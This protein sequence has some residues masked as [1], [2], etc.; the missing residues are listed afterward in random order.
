VKDTGSK[1]QSKS[2]AAAKAQYNHA[3]ALYELGQLKEAVDVLSALST[4]YPEHPPI[5][6]LLGKAVERTGNTVLARKIYEHAASWMTKHNPI[7]LNCLLSADI[8]I[9]DWDNVDIHLAEVRKFWAQGQVNEVELF[10]LMALPVSGQDLKQL[11]EASMATRF[12]PAKPWPA[13]ARC[14]RQRP[15]RL[16][17]GYFSADFHGHATAVLMAG[18][19]EAHDKS[20]FETVG[21]CFGRYGD[22]PDD[23]MRQR[24]RAAFD[25]FEIVN[26]MTAFDIATKARSLNIDIAVD[27]KGHT[28]D[29]RMAIFSHRAAPIQIHYIGYPGTLGMPGAIDYLVADPVL[30]PP[31]MRAN[32]SEKIITL[33]DSYQVNDRQ[34]SIAERKPSRTELG[35]P[36]HGFVFCCFNNNHKITR[37]VFALWMELLQA[38][39]GSVLWLLEDNPVAG[40]NLRAAAA[41]A[42]IDERRLVFA[43][44]APLP[45]HLARHAQADLFLDTFYYNAH[46]TASDALWVGLP[47][48]TCAGGTF[49]SRVGASLLTACDLPELIT[50]S[51]RDYLDLALA[52][53]ADPARLAALRQRLQNTRLQV[54]L[55]DTER[56]TRHI[57]RAYD[58]AWERFE[59]GLP[60][61]HITVP[62]IQS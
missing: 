49:S 20:R 25:R 10:R 45:Q 12:P 3:L 28:S 43:Q 15:E 46:T 27:L 17:I 26:K 60:P 34:R 2:A 51:P 9:C 21:F 31:Q 57:E 58:M 22:K 33:P 1:S 40:A 54:P 48:L 41:A 19:F 14:A 11:T 44:R 6:I 42:G 52:L 59:R 36:E 7:I 24:V 5:W 61:D 53:S 37:D 16:R 35:L 55:F 18:M 4:Q 30:V 39:P 8:A 56:F 38:R 32:Y 23:P 62:S 50:T 47:V 29:N 13:D